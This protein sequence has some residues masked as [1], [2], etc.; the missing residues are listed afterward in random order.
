M[1]FFLGILISKQIAPASLFSFQL[2]IKTPFRKNIT[3]DSVIFLR[4]WNVKE[5]PKSYI[6][7]KPK[8]VTGYTVLLNEKFMI[9]FQQNLGAQLGPC[10]PVG[11]D[12]PGLKREKR[13]EK[14]SISTLTTISCTLNQTQCTIANLFP[15]WCHKKHHLL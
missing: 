5:T 14:K 7:K 9:L 12:G 8:N 6:W 4:K 10:T 2:R 1:F 13:R 15:R 3:D 11:S